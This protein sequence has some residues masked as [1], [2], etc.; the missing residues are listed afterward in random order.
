MNALTPALARMQTASDN[1]ELAGQLRARGLY[2]VT[3]A[4]FVK[5]GLAW[6]RVAVPDPEPLPA[7]APASSVVEFPKLP[8]PGNGPVPVKTPKAT[9]APPP[10][11]PP[12]TPPP[13]LAVGVEVG[14]G[15]GGDSALSQQHQDAVKR[16]VAK[17]T[18]VEA[19]QV[20]VGASGGSGG[21]R[22]LRQAADASAP[23]SQKL[24]LSVAP[25]PGQGAAVRAALDKLATGDG[26][27]RLADAVRAEGWPSVQRASVATANGSAPGRGRGAAA[28]TVSNTP[29]SGGAI[30]G[31]V[32]GALVTAALI[33]GVIVT[34]ILLRTHRRP[35]PS[36]LPHAP[37]LMAA[38][39]AQ[40]D[41]SAVSP[42]M[43]SVELG[44]TKATPSP[45]PRRGFA[46]LGRPRAPPQPP[47][48]LGTE[49]VA[50]GARRDLA[51]IAAAGVTSL[52]RLAS[53]AAGR[54][55][56]AGGSASAA[57]TI[58]PP[59]P[60]RPTGAPADPLDDVEDAV[61][62]L[63]L[64]GTPFAG[65]YAADAVLRRG[66][67]TL[68]VAARE[69]APPRRPVVL[70]FFTSPDEFRHE[71]ALAA[72]LPPGEA[73]PAVLDAFAAG[74]APGASTLP[75]CVVSEAGDYSLADWPRK[76]SR[77]P[78][79]VQRRAVLAMVA[80]AVARLHAKGVVHGGLCPDAVLWFSGANAMKLG[81]LAT[82][83]PVGGAA[84]PPP[85]PRY[86]APE[87]VAAVAKGAATVPATAAADSWAL[88][89]LA[90]W[91]FTDAPLLPNAGDAAAA[92][93][94][95]GDAGPLPWEARPA[96]LVKLAPP[97]AAV[98]TGL[99]ARDPAARTAAA[100]VL[101]SPLFRSKARRPGS[102]KTASAA[103]A[104]T[105]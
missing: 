50:D 102:G 11:P 54:L 78:D 87:I 10:P 68:E 64:R 66:P 93:A 73:T 7:P 75:A 61:A 13:P 6:D 89:A 27:Q 37:K 45:P 41:G 22:R 71:G 21:R 26:A 83:A 42:G 9:P 67:R 44:F 35:P 62:D 5:Y 19:D 36:A 70:K 94:A 99:L 24:A 8:V 34:A 23:W 88:G 14:G 74:G 47:P 105:K 65:N 59:R 72:K 31:I 103:S 25:A 30:A 91:I 57:T 16:A 3:D 82:W 84:S 49:G 98:I 101:T 60:P 28:E 92:A 38:A 90:Y 104:V 80:K 77:T 63:A 95:L 4:R 29:L 76:R 97:V 20:T 18:G 51:S 32:I 96:A 1:S 86:A 69:V 43:E 52:R 79:D 48:T 15:A 17:L 55:S 33:A 46:G 81:R 40:T 12:A 85:D 2:D 53:G 100:D 58:S 39:S 56:A